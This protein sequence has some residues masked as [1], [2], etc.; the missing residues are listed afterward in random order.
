MTRKKRLAMARL[1]GARK[2]SKEGQAWRKSTP[3]NCS[4]GK[5]GCRPSSLGI[6]AGPRR[7][8]A[9]RRL[10]GPPLRRRSHAARP[11]AARGGRAVQP[12]MVPG[13]RR[14]SLR[15][16]RP[17]AAAPARIRQAQRRNAP[18]AGRRTRRQ[19]GPVRPL[20][21]A[22][23]GVLRLG[24]R[25]SRGPSQFRA[26]RPARPIPRGEPGPVAAGAG[27]DRRGLRQQPAARGPGPGRPGRGGLPRPQAGRQ[28]AGRHAGPP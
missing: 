12:A 10:R 27:V 11:D 26:A 4:S 1:Q 17:V 19:L 16:P 8:A 13:G 22:G 21:R 15:P 14:R 25:G 23:D 18:R 6:A 28:G 20:R 5:A 3:G 9:R 2:W 7:R 24:G